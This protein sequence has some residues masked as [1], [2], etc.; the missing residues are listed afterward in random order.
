MLIVL[1]LQLFQPA[2]ASAQ[3]PQG[4]SQPVTVGVWINPPF[5]MKKDD[6]YTGM[7][8]RLWEMLAEELN[9]EYEY[10][11]Y[12]TVRSLVD[13]TAEGDSDIA[14][15]NL[16]ITRNRAQRVDFTQPWYD[17]GL[18]VMI[19]GD[20]RSGFRDIIAG[21]ADAGFLRAYAWLVGIIIFATILL[22]IF[23]RRFNPDFP[24]R[25]RDGVA[26][27]FYTVM[28]VATSGRP[29]SRKN[30]FGWLG[31]MWQGVWLI[32]G[33]AVIAY[34]TSTVTSVMT[35]LSLTNQISGLAD[36]PGKTVGVFEGSVAEE[37]IDATGI[38]YVSY[39]GIDSAAEA[40][41]A[42]DIA[43]IVGDAPTLEY[44]T[45]LNAEEPYQVVGKIF[46]PDKYGFALPQ[47]SPL[48]KSLT[49]SLLTLKEKG[50]VEDL[51]SDYFSSGR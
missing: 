14:V 18:R 44:Y 12:P 10:K 16:T 9:L 46:N 8:I 43:A 28:S 31:R 30:L 29:P 19:D 25:W 35:T 5:V 26:E 20:R 24:K 47:N 42:D 39:N 6:A 15:T 11:E 36:L 4:V 51:R 34:V 21:L 48:T 45:E 38:D 7:A 23:D 1:G 2:I 27:S 17:A 37:F 3:T 13:A 32:C 40:L 22:T 41:L 49:L 50:A 33:I